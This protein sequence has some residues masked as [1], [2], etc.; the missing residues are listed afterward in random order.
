MGHPLRYDLFGNFPLAHSLK[1]I[2]F[3]KPLSQWDAWFR[4]ENLAHE[5][6]PWHHPTPPSPYLSHPTH[7]AN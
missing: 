2:S 4:Q 7:T 3:N 5:R 1:Q 6:N